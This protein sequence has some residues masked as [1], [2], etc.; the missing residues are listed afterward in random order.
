[1]SAL[2][3]GVMLGDCG[4]RDRR[5]NTVVSLQPVLFPLELP[6]S[7]EYITYSWD[8]RQPSC[9]LSLCTIL[10]AFHLV[11]SLLDG[12]LRGLAL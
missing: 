11:P 9:F 8:C 6:G 1:M 5:Y 3:R 10:I 2:E 7:L 4:D 12:E